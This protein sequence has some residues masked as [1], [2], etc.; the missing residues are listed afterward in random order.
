M[1]KSLLLGLSVCVISLIPVTA[2][3]GRPVTIDDTMKYKNIT[4]VELAPDGKRVAV[5]D[6]EPDF[7]ENTIR[8][9]IYLSDGNAAFFKLTNGT[10]HDDTPRWSPDGKWL[11]FISDRDNKPEKAAKKQVWLIS[12]N[13]GEAWQLTRSKI[14][15]SRIEWA[16]DG[17]SMAL[18]AT[19]SPTDEQEKKIKDKDDAVVMERDTK[20][21]RIYR[22]SVPEGKTEL[23]YAAERHITSLS[24]SPK[25]DEIAFADQPSPK[26]PDAYNSVVRAVS[27]VGKKVRDLSPVELACA[28][29]EFAPDGKN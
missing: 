22:V 7:D 14:S 27:V 29:P 18:I 25:G 2:F 8:T 21:A 15:I 17:K 9:N 20:L 28:S 5:D 11:A 26:V 23:L 13:G 1:K 19:E 16:P 10:K 4:H 24:F 12:P 6:S 3:A